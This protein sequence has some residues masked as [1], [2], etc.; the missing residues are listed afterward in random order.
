MILNTDVSGYRFAVPQFTGI[1]TGQQIGTI[2]VCVCDPP[3]LWPPCWITCTHHFSRK[4][5][6]KCITRPPERDFLHTYSVSKILIAQC[7]KKDW[8]GFNVPELGISCGK[9]RQNAILNRVV[10]IL[11]TRD[12]FWAKGS[13]RYW[14]TGKTTFAAG[15]HRKSNPVMFPECPSC[16]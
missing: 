4:T 7:L 8:C 16:T 5:V 3:T 12:S 14:E 2:Y 6:Q 15:K 11:L 9:T 1:V 10:T 13:T